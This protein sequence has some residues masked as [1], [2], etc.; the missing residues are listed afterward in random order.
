MTCANKRAVFAEIQKGAPMKDIQCLRKVLCRYL[1]MG[2]VYEC[3]VINCNQLFL[4]FNKIGKTNSYDV[5]Q[6]LLINFI[7]H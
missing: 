2:D 6:G 3:H 7:I 5:F 4:A 1:D